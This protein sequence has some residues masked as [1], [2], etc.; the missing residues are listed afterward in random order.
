MLG[1]LVLLCSFCAIARSSFDDYKKEVFT[2]EKTGKWKGKADSHVPVLDLDPV[3]GGGWTAQMSTTHVKTD[4]HYIAKHWVEDGDGN[5][6]ASQEF[7]PADDNPLNAH[8]NQTTKFKVAKGTREPLTT[9]AWCNLH[10]T[11]AHT[12]EVQLSHWEDDV[13]VDEHGNE[14]KAKEEDA[15]DG[16]KGQTANM[17]KASEV[18]QNAKVDADEINKLK[19]KVFTVEQPGQWKGKATAHVPSLD[20]EPVTGGGWIAEVT[21]EHGKDISNYIMKHWIEDG[22]GT[23]LGV[24]DFDINDETDSN[25]AGNQVSKFHIPRGAVEPLSTFAH[26]SSHGTWSHEWTTLSLEHTVGSE[27]K[28]KEEL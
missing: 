9:Y 27:E 12:W 5:V 3:K 24:I 2:V 13:K 6:I 22:A 20:M 28:S 23:I 21:T 25:R 15:T 14:I 17:K 18:P 7:S 10:G 8:K 1:S 16:P 11:W 19:K 26:C 4:T